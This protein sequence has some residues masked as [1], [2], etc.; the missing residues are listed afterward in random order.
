M[1][2]CFP[3]SEAQEIEIYSDTADDNLE[4]DVTFKGP[5]GSFC[6]IPFGDDGVY[7]T[8]ETIF[9]FTLMHKLLG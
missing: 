6:L 4:W 7:P 5:P 8:V 2:Q 3:I 9:L 1:E